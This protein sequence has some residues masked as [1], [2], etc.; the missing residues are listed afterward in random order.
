MLSCKDEYDDR[1]NYFLDFRPRECAY[2]FIIPGWSAPMYDP[3]NDFH[4]VE[5][6]NIEN[7]SVNHE[8]FFVSIQTSNNDRHIFSQYPM[9]VYYLDMSDNLDE[10][11]PSLEQQI[12]RDFAQMN[13]KSSSSPSSTEGLAYT[14]MIEMEYRLTGIRNFKIT[15]LD[16]SLF[17]KAEGESL[18]DFFD[19]I[20]YEPQII[21]SSET[22]NLLMGFTTPADEL[23]SSIDEWLSLKPLGQPTMYLQPNTPLGVSLPVEVRFAIEVETNEGA[24]LRDTT[25]VFTITN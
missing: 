20:R 1:G 10:P 19:I 15:A 25:S 18:N 12:E 22:H 5:Y 3:Y 17:G 11:I 23:P 8:Q 2:V 7:N 14:N 4:F 21:A 6:K 24:V 9:P 16:A 13:K